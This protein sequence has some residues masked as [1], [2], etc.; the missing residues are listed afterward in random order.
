MQKAVAGNLFQRRGAA[1]LAFPHC[2][3]PGLAVSVDAVAM[4]EALERVGLLPRPCCVIRG[5]L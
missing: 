3:T 4:F 1:V 5:G 2:V